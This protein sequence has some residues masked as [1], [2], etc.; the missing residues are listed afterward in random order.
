MS[1]A[2]NTFTFAPMDLAFYSLVFILIDVLNFN[3]KINWLISNYVIVRIVS[4]M[5]PYSTMTC[6]HVIIL[7]TY[8]A[9]AAL[10][11]GT[12]N[13]HSRELIDLKKGNSTWKENG[14]NFK[15]NY[16]K[17]TSPLIRLLMIVYSIAS[18]RIQFLF[19][20]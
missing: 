2:P 6:A 12:E 9:V 18:C 3:C 1:R 17:I 16:P 5:V 10:L 15:K 20:E 13:D 7:K 14:S 11:W 19:L 8:P 4:L